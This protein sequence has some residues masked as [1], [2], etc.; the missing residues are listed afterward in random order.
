MS[1]QLLIFITFHSCSLSIIYARASYLANDLL[2]RQLHIYI[3]IYIYLSIYIYIY[4]YIYISAYIV[5]QYTYL[6][7]QCLL[8]SSSSLLSTC[9]LR[10]CAY[11]SSDCAQKKIT[12]Y[13]NFF[14]NL[15]FKNIV[16]FFKKTCWLLL[17]KD[18]VFA[19]CLYNQY[20]VLLDD[21]AYQVYL[22]HLLIIESETI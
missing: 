3:Y 14:R 22:R 16:I 4:I 9:A 15:N 8:F 2:L 18:C 11:G 6:L 10:Q 17:A 12:V 5:H 7:C 1:S 19:R 21:V 13:R 20:T